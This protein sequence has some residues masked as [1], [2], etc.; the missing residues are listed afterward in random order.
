MTG[1][2]Y[3][4][5]PHV[6]GD[7]VA[8][9][10]ED[11][12]WLAPVA[13]GRAWRLSS[14]G[15][16][17]RNP[18]FAPDG[19]K[20]VW[21][22]VQGSAPE[23]VS[24]D[25]D[26]GGFRQLSWFGHSTTRVK[27]FTPDGRVVVTS[28]H[29]QPD[30]RHTHAYSI[31]VDGGWLEE[32]PYGPV[33]SVAFGPSVGDDRPVVVGSVLTRD[34]AHW[35]RYRGGA[36]G[37]LWIDPDGGGEFRRLATGLDG[38]LADPM[39]AGGRIAF[40]SDHEGV[41]NLY[42]VD[43][44]GGDLARHTDLDR[45]YARHAST[46]GRRVVFESAGEL[47]M[48]DG[49]DAE[50]RRLEVALASAST[51]RRTVPL[52]VGRHLGEVVPTPDGRASVVESHGTVHWLTHR[53]G[54]SRVVEA[55]PGVRARLARPLGAD[56]VVFIADHDGEEGLF[57]RRLAAD[58]AAA[59]HEAPH[60]VPTTHDGAPAGGGDVTAHSLPLPVS[61]R[62]RG[63]FDAQGAAGAADG[64]A[65]GSD[66]SVGG[67][68]E[69]AGNAT[70]PAR[71]T[72][73]MPGSAGGQ[74]S[75]RS[76]SVPA[77]TAVP[78]A[79]EA[80]TLPSLRRIALPSPHRPAELVPSP[81]A[82]FIAVGTSFGDVYLVDAEHGTA[83]TLSTVEEGTIEQ[84]A[85]S[86]DSR[87][88]SWSEP[89]TAFGARSKVRLAERETGRVAD[90]TDGRFWDAWPAFTPDG[91]YLAFLSGR[92]FDPVYDGH[93]FDLSF[94]SPIKPYIVPLAATTSSPFGP[95]VAEFTS[96]SAPEDAATDSDPA[97]HDDAQSY[98]T[99]PSEG[100]DASEGFTP[101][102]QHVDHIEVTVDLEG[103]QHR[104]TSLPVRQGNYSRLTATKD[105]L[106]WMSQDLTGATGEGK[107][108]PSDKD[109]APTLHRLDLATGAETTIVSALERYRV[110]A[111]GSRVVYVRERSVHSVPSDKPA[112][113]GHGEHVSVDLDRI[114]VRLDP[115][116]VWAQAFD[117]AWRLQRD[118]YWTD[119][120]AGADWDEVRDRY[121]P[122]VPRLGS[123]DDLVDLL[124]EMHGELGT[125]HAYVTPTLVTEPGAGGQ[126]RLGG[127][128]DF[129]GGWVVR[130]VL[131]SESS[132]PLASSPLA[133]SGAGVR[134][135]DRLLAVDGV[136]LTSDFGPA[137]ALAGAAGKVVELTMLNGSEHGDRAGATRRIAVVP[138]RD[139]ERLRYQ[140][141][142]QANRRLVREAS[143]GRFGYL[144]V[145]DMGARGWAQLHRD[146]DTETA[147]DALVVDVR[148]NRGGHTSQLV[149]EL[150]GRRVIGWTMPRGE[151]P[152]TYP[153]HAPR[154]PVVILA[155][156][157]AGSDG[158]I[159]TQVGK[160]RGIGPVVGTRTWGGV[161][162]IDNRFKLADGTSVTQPRYATWF[163][164]GI[165]WGVENFGVE[166]D[167]EVP[168]PPQAYAA[169]IDPQLEHGIGVLK[170]MLVEIPTQRPP[171]REGYRSVHPTAL[172]PRPQDLAEAEAV[173][174]YE[175]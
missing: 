88:L 40:L 139:E 138:I 87:W 16:P 29:N 151:Q 20:V 31:P 98:L 75:L 134:P 111:D 115:I 62:G 91:K 25:V 150:I 112:E 117:E 3:F 123:H 114:R 37:K 144:H 51:S 129:D 58:P 145:P 142:V 105:A 5:Y 47:W 83:T 113:D 118:F 64:A 17:A 42:S 156:E 149:A 82:K 110:S 126:G 4:R 92:S 147:L 85:W 119:D 41:G 153:R 132:D 103:I 50:P 57:I 72:P 97:T 164:G 135:G 125:S 165:G 168:Y 141:W 162:G 15:L 160:L 158:D 127:E 79:D 95:R 101:A 104:I 24:A 100:T 56:S 28:A 12:V 146:L 33:D 81:D 116:A 175:G 136:P 140:E 6:H 7:L 18:R 52:A 102:G 53:D 155:D 70:E 44:T 172:P 154:G 108:K 55:T 93:S 13:G 86:P 84:L 19:S 109:A 174:A 124:W 54:P 133:S 106:L 26:G 69:G 49:L 73:D 36:E 63:G 9:V 166:P 80:D 2:S 120:M 43:R 38:N 96:E 169:G 10:A 68:A 157:F 143:E 74:R 152:R 34:P 107:A 59:P 27:G 14:L 99:E 22:V 45:F 77:R 90:V 161:I 65:A 122:L 61:A 66:V 89:V 71:R 23:V 137:I 171:A 8:F 94:P 60:T 148:R 170:E 76:Y 32:L 21:T 159:I 48:L 131:A 167:I 39:W 163:E 11:D 78:A 46:D 121:R 128:F 130:R 1:S 30:G 173:P 35:K 67:P